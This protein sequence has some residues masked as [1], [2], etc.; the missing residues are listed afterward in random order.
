VGASVAAIDLAA[1]AADWAGAGFTIDE[2][3][4]CRVGAT[5]LRLGRESGWALRD[6]DGDGPVEGIPTERVDWPAPA[7]AEHANGALSVDH[8]VVVT[9]DVDR[10]FAALQATAMTLRR[11]RTT[12]ERRYGFFRHGECIVEV[13]GPAE[14][15]AAGGDAA[16]WGLTITVADLDATAA[17]LGDRLGTIRDA[18]QPGRRIATVR[19]GAGLGVPLAFMSG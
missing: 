9:P 7:G 8:V 1:P 2:D 13:V 4:S 5:V 17:L 12:G 19:S 11:E 16:L 6:A 10:T 15:D 3:G 18:V 14:P